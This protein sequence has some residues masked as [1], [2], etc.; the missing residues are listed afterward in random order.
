MSH[1]PAPPTS[2]TI[3]LVRHG[4]TEG[5]SSIRYHGRN[6][7]ALSDAGR[8]Q[9]RAAARRLADNRFDAVFTSTLIRTVE[10]ATIIAPRIVATPV[11]GFDEIHFGSWEG[12]T[13]SE[14]EAIDPDLFREWRDNLEAFTY[15]GGDSVRGFRERVTSA[16]TQLRPE[17]P[18]RT[19]IV[20]HRGVIAT[21]LSE[22]LGL[23]PQQRA[24]LAIDLGSVHV[25][26]FRDQGWHPTLMNATEDSVR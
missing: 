19:L 18:P 12:L 10:A 6:D 26:E 2:R 15:P 17:L 11:P 3:V 16:F 4:E 23:G 9:M 22:L 20:A 21:V 8:E 25:L 7:V 13:S 14:I 5:E 1:L 24:A